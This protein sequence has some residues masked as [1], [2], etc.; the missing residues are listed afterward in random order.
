MDNPGEDPNLAGFGGGIPGADGPIAGGAPGDGG[1]DGEN[2]D[3]FYD[4]GGETFLPADHVSTLSKTVMVSNAKC[5]GIPIHSQE[6][7]KIQ[8]D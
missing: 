7:S 1:D 8:L 6:V 3:Q 5:G 4:D 2:V